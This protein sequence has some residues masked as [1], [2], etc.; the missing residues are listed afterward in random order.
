[1]KEVMRDV[2]LKLCSIFK[3]MARAQ[4][5]FTIFKN[6]KIEILVAKLHDKSKNIIPVIYR[7]TLFIRNT[8]LSDT[9]CF[10]I[11]ISHSWECYFPKLLC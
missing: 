1:M 5:Q 6:L 4:S 10:E 2:F 7:E 8:C 3:R 11:I 9:S